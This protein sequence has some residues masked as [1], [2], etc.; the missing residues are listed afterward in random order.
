M[1][2]LRKYGNRRLYD[3]TRSAYVNLDEV[4][5]LLRAGEDVR[6]EDARDGR[7][8]TRS[9]LL[10]VLLEVDGSADALPVVVLR[11][12][13]ALTG[14]ADAAR[15]LHET[16]TRATDAATREDPASTATRW[17]AAWRAWT[18]DT[19]PD[20]FLDL[21]LPDDDDG[22]G[23]LEDLRASMDSLEARLTRSGG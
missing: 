2:I 13:I 5:R 22:V 9:V 23:P 6:V 15:G 11:R 12:S 4:A 10:Q 20:A 1:R 8:L 14:D 17:D 18:G 3:T 21:P 16:L 19:D 7:D